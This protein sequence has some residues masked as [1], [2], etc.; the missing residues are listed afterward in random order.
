MA[1]I[2]NFNRKDKSLTTPIIRSQRSSCAVAI[3]R[4]A[5][6]DITKLV[7]IN[8]VNDKSLGQGF[9]SSSAGNLNQKDFMIVR[10]DI[11]RCSVSNAKNGGGSF[12]LILKRGKTFEKG[13]NAKINTNDNVDYLNAINPGDWI[14][15]Y[16][17]RSGELSLT[18][19]QSASPK[20]G[21]KFIGIVENVRLLETDNSG[22]GTPRL[23]VMITGKSFAKVFETNI[24]HNPV[25]NQKDIEAVLGASFLSEASKSVKSV[26][27]FSAD[28]VI[29]KLLQFY[30]QGTGTAKSA[31]N[32]NWYVPQRLAQTLKGF[33][34]TKRLS[35]G[36]YDIL[37]R[38]KIGVQKF[39]NGT[40]TGV[41]AMSG[42][43]LV[44]SLPSSGTIWS[45]M[46]FMQNSVI[47]ELFTELTF[48]ATTKT[49][50][51]AVIMRRIPFSN[52]P[53]HET[54]VFKAHG[55][56]SNNRKYGDPVTAS[57]KTFFIDLPKHVITSSDIKSKNIGK[58]DH[59]R[60]NYALV[61]P[62]IT[63]EAVVDALFTAISNPAS[64]QRYGLKVFN[65]QTSYV[66]DGKIGLTN[67]CSKC[68][69]MLADWFFLGH[70]LYNGSILIQGIDEHIEIGNNLFIKDIKQLF[71]IESYT[72]SFVA[73]PSGT[74]FYE[75]ELVV[76]RG[77]FF[78][79][80]N[81][82][83]FIASSNKHNES[84]TVITS[85]LPK[86]TEF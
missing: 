69:H 52:K 75:T 17:K 76:S 7:P 63:Q 65:A 79:G 80:S 43:A 40:F 73:D 13:S 78:N 74:V 59:E 71:H 24:F 42:A 48:N 50:E 62:R 61:V 28:S 85:F 55:K 60:I 20:S 16:M 81:V 51:P 35:R 33:D 67:Y 22:T 86:G 44:T 31:A 37:N 6:E 77:Q 38:D 58:S 27:G 10:Q 2:Q 21:L 36:F 46:Q 3:Y 32:E 8:A 54:N 64:I 23:D 45:V 1:D 82:A 47:N 12:S 49:L 11:V 25:V 29:K 5:N 57:E 83:A 15:I 39:K 72:H 9:N 18:D 4:Y 19:L 53:E 26:P 56:F 66:L 70:N 34:K 30:L 14:M 41:N 68:V 84:T